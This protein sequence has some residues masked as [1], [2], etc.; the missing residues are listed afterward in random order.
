MRHR[1]RGLLQREPTG[2]LGVGTPHGEQAAGSVMVRDGPCN[3]GASQG[4]TQEGFAQE[5]DW[6][7]ELA[8]QEDPVG[9]WADLV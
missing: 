4:D 7:L 8:L 1:R 9:P 3:G 5:Q 6:L 2:P